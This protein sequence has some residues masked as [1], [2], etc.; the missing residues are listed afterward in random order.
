[1]ADNGTNLLADFASAVAGGKI[2]V[3]DITQTLNEDTPTLVL[4]D[5]FQQAA[6][7]SR[8]ELSRYDER[9]V[10]WYWNNFT[11]C[12]HTGTHF[13]A[14]VHW[15]SGRDLENNTLEMIP[16]KD[17]I[18]PAVVIDCSAECAADPD[19]LLTADFIRKW[20]AEHGTDRAQ[21]LGTDAHRL[22]EA[23]MVTTTPIAERTARIRRAR[24]PAR[25]SICW[26]SATSSASAWKPSAPTRGRR[27]CSNRHTRRTLCCMVR[28]G[29]ACN[30][31]KDSTGFPRPALSSSPLHSRSKT[32]R[33]ARCACSRWFRNKPSRFSPAGPIWPG[34]TVDAILFYT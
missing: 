9:G 14:P 20:E 5:E 19:F 12:E 25:S 13:D 28:D 26:K 22:V 11:V 17:F 10:A 32:A 3:I 34:G 7:F 6:G 33:A 4:P 8:Q 21:E 23:G 15:V 1:M 27:T 30:A 29:M 24:T 18:G 2:R 16:P 31:C